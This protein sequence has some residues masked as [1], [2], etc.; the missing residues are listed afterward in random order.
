MK[1]QLETNADIV[2][3]EALSH[4]NGIIEPYL[5]RFNNKDDVLPSFLK[6]ELS[7]TVWGRLIRTS[8]Y[9]DNKIKCIDGINF[10]EVFQVIPKLF[11]YAKRVSGISDFIY[12]YNCDNA[13][14]YVSRIKGNF[15]LKKQSIAAF[16]EINHFFSDKE[17]EL[18]ILSK[19]ALILMIKYFL[20][21]SI[22]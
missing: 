22:E 4:K 19:K 8:L 3:G 18:Q 13:S 9:K 5:S 14:S 21:E 12:H 16:E 7:H 10:G 2:T 17:P 6:L 11:Y 20:K 15:E 1:K